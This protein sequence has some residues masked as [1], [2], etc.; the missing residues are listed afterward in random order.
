[1]MR[2]FRLPTIAAR[3]HAVRL[4]A[5]FAALVLALGTIVAYPGTTLAWDAGAFSAADEQ[6]LFTLTNQDRASAG[7]NALTNDTYLHNKARWR[8]QDMGD[9]NYFSHYIPP[10]NKMVFYY[11][12]HDGYCYK[13]A[14]ENIGVSTY[15]DS[16]ATSHIE[17]A[18]MASPGHRANIL[19][20]WA[21]M[22]IGAYKSAAGKKLYTVLFS[23][24]CGV[25]VPT[26]A[27]IVTP[28]PTLAP[29]ATPTPVR[30]AA[31]KPTTSTT[32]TAAPVGTAAPSNA[33]GASASPSAGASASPSPT[34]APTSSPTATPAA[35]VS[36]TPVPSAPPGPGTQSLRVRPESASPN[37]MQSFLDWLF[38]GLL[39]W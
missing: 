4:R 37:P 38:G 14:G 39:H 35:A 8:A 7:L 32:R 27:P 12:S 6:L 1:M 25:T 10:D 15:G 20:T 19:G 29:G 9:R 22:G 3:S 36:P 16:D 11:M 28:A 31:P 33:T 5:I 34:P 17:I 30:T 2:G 26:P 24:P 18:F 13:V 21:R 23:V